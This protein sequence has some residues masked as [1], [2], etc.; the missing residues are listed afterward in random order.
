MAGSVKAR[1]VDLEYT[2]LDRVGGVEEMKGSSRVRLGILVRS[3]SI[4]YGASTLA[5]A[6]RAKFSEAAE[7]FDGLDPPAETSSD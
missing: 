7:P 1:V 2:R 5:S 3:I 4:G 6:S